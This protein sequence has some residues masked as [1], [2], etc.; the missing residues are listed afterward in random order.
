MKTRSLCLFGLAALLLQTGTSAGDK[1]EKQKSPREALQ[2]FNDQIGEWRA[3]GTP[4]G[5]KKE[6]QEGFWT[7]TMTWGWQFKDK[8]AW[9]KIDVAKGKY[10]LDGTLRY[11]AEKDQFELVMRNLKKESRTY[12]GTIKDKTLTMESK[13]GGQSDRLVFTLLHSNRF[14]YRQEIQKAEG[15]AFTKLYSVGATKEGVP[16]AGPDGKPECIV[17]GGLGTMTVSYMGQTYY[18][19]CSGCRDEF[20]ANPQKYIKEFEDR[21][22][23]KK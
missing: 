14:L 6:Q 18:V 1:K 10:F 22:K 5:T 21:K 19:C 7:E 13:D 11:N 3:T 15:A 17:S 2:A 4:V 23:A 12:T 9:I 8:D 20:V 16:F